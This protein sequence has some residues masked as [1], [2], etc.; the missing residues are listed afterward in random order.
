MYLSTL[1]SAFRSFFWLFNYSSEEWSMSFWSSFVVITDLWKASLLLAQRRSWWEDMCFLKDSMS[2]EWLFVAYEGSVA[3]QDINYSMAA[4]SQVASS[5]SLF[6]ESCPILAFISWVGSA[7]SLLPIS[8]SFTLSKLR[9]ISS[10]TSVI[11][12]WASNYTEV[13]VQIPIGRENT[14]GNFS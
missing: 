7:S 2:F 8:F 9:A 14:T 3:K 13:C 11:L 4:F 12:Q 1:R 10:T 6:G 5:F